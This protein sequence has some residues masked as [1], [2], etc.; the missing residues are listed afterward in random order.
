[1]EAAHR[2]EPLLILRENADPGGALFILPGVLLA[3]VWVKLISFLSNY[4]L[5]MAVGLPKE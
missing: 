1:M 2:N 4:F 5:D 3:T